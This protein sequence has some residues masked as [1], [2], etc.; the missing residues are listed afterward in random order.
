MVRHEESAGWSLR[1]RKEMYEQDDI[2]RILARE[3]LSFED[4]KIVMRFARYE[5]GFDERF[6]YANT[7]LSHAGDYLPPHI[8]TALVRADITEEDA[9]AHLD[10]NKAFFSRLTAL[11]PSLVRFFGEEARSKNSEGIISCIDDCHYDFH[12]GAASSRKDR[13]LREAKE[14]LV[15]ASKLSNELSAALTDVQRLCDIE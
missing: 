12:V 14:K 13:Q 3:E 9:A 6:E 15:S 10:R 2:A 1:R 5:R 4:V 7:L 11:L 8:L